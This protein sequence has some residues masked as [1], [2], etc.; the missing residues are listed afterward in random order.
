MFASCF[1]FGQLHGKGFG[2][3]NTVGFRRLIKIFCEGCK[4]CI[5]LFFFFLS[6]VGVGGGGGEV[7]YRLIVSECHQ[8]SDFFF[9]LILP[10]TSNRNDFA[11]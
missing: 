1:C 5:F 7:F 4:N 9:L 8:G 11:C 10:F 3:Q 2:L 6:F